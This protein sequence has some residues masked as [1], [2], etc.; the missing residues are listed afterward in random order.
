[1]CMYIYMYHACYFQMVY[2]YGIVAVG[3]WGGLYHARDS[4][5]NLKS[6]CYILILINPKEVDCIHERYKYRMSGVCK[7]DGYAW[8]RLNVV[9]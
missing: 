8:H 9:V 6:Q 4:H 5:E 2:Y 1:M 3:G 7:T